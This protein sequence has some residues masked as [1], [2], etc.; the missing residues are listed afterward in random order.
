MSRGDERYLFISSEEFRERK[1]WYS[2]IFDLYS[3]I[4]F[5]FKEIL[6]KKN[7]SQGRKSSLEMIVLYLNNIFK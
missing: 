4:Y 2:L 1:L 5:Y 7:S 3:S 6:T